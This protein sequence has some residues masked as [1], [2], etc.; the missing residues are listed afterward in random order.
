MSC[1]VWALH[2][3]IFAVLPMFIAIALLG[4]S[5]GAVIARVIPAWTGVIGVVGAG[6]LA[7]GATL[8]PETA[9]T[10]SPLLAVSMVGFAGWLVFL[11]VAGLRLARD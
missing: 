11:V 3:A 6:L 1:R 7:V 10:T 4:L 2:N 9:A 5:R 8:A